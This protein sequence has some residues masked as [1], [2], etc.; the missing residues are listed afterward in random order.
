MCWQKRPSPGDILDGIE[1]GV[2]TDHISVYVSIS[3]VW[4]NMHA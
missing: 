2:A 1:W 4:E 3:D